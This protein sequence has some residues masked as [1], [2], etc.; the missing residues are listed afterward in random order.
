MEECVR[1][2]Q[3][4]I[5]PEMIKAG[6]DAYK[7]FYADLQNGFI[8]DDIDAE[9]VSAVFSVMRKV[10]VWVQSQNGSL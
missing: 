1:Q 10:Q 7:E 2:R 9:M 3:P 8:R 5:T 6:V 4:E